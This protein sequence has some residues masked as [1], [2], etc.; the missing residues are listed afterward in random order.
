M[1]IFDF[2]KQGTA[3]MRLARPGA[4]R[5]VVHLHDEQELPLYGQLEVS[6]LDAAVFVHAGRAIGIVGPGRHTLHASKL[7]FLE[8][9]EPREGRLPVR[10]AF[11]RLAPV[12]RARF[13]AR[14]DDDP[15]DLDARGG[16][17][18]ALAGEL[19]VQVVDPMAFVDEWL[20]VGE[21]PLLSCAGVA[22]SV[23]DVQLVVEGAR[24]E[25]F[26]GSGLQGRPQPRSVAPPSMR[27]ATVVCHGCGTPGEAGTFCE[28]CGA[29]LG[30]IERCISCRAVLEPNARFCASCGARVG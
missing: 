14:L 7:A 1:G 24:T 9:I 27:A 19:T 6:R 3:D 12:D 22:A 4:A 20:R 13:S 5:G 16:D 23:D 29:L 21:R 11:V 30:D 15:T 2:V 28:T 8:G 17:P 25:L 26:A 10:V 18:P